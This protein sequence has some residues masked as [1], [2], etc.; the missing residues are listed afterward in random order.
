MKNYG[1]KIFGE[2]KKLRRLLEL[3]KTN[4]YSAPQLAEIFNCCKKPIHGAL[5]RAG[6]YL[7]NLGKFKKRYKHNEEFFTKL[8]PTSTYWAGFITADGCLYLRGKQE[9]V[10]YLTLKHADINHLRKFRKTIRSNARIGCVKS[11]NSANL[12][13][14]SCDKVFDSLLNL[15]IKPHKNL[16]DEKIRIPNGL[17]SHFIRGVFDGDGSVSGKKIT[18]VQFQIAGYKPL[19]KQIQDTLIKKCNVKKVKFYPLDYK[20]EGKAFRL[21]YTGSQIFRILK[22]L[23][24]NSAPRIRLE[25]K[26]KKYLILKKKFKK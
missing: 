7:P 20:K 5:N 8:T 17:M 11:N 15:G 14:Y 24:K 25:R 21:Q 9:K 10:F 23:Y 19:L 1:A 18:H 16:R 22:F 13:F 6:I 4:K 12:R 26:Y 3:A 2:R